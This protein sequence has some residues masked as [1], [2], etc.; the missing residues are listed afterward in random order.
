MFFTFVLFLFSKLTFSKTIIGTLS[1]CKTVCIQIWTDDLSIVILVQPLATVISKRE[2]SLLHLCMF[3]HFLFSLHFEG[4]QIIG[5]AH[6]IWYLSHKV[7]HPFNMH[8]QQHVSSGAVGLMFGPSLYGRPCV[9]AGWE[10]S[11][12]TVKLLRFV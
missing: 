12:K 1:E 2:R 11:C 9:W 6:E 4:F 3:R 8:A 10:G 7:S 5:R